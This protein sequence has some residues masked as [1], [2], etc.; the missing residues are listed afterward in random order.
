MLITEKCKITGWTSLCPPLII[1]F[2]FL[3]HSLT[4]DTSFKDV[5]VITDFKTQL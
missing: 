2:L 1:K 5:D 3:G 4:T